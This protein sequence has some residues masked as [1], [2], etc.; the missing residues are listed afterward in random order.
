MQNHIKKSFF[1]ICLFFNNI[2]FSQTDKFTGIS[3]RLDSLLKTNTIRPF[4][5]EIIITEKGKKI[6]S[7]SLGYADFEKKIPLKLKNQFVI[8]SISKQITAVLILREFDKKHLNLNDPISKYLKELK[9]S[10]ADS[11]SIHQ[12]LNHTSGIV[13][14]NQPLAFKPGTK[15]SYSGDGY[16]LLGEIVERTSGNTFAVLLKKLFNKCKMTGSTDPGSNNKKNL[17]TGYSRQSDQTVKVEKETFTNN[18]VAAGLMISTVEDLIL[19]N[20]NLH[21][22]K[23]LSKESYKKMTTASSIRN[24]PIYGE[25]GYGY[26]IQ[27]NE[28]NGIL[29]LGHV[30]YVP[31]FVSINF[32][33]PKDNIGLI[34]LE[35]IDWK[36]D[37]FK[38]T[39][40]FEED[41]RRMVREASLKK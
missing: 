2:S 41:V 34:M 1:L 9:Q 40:C 24:H 28:K 12:L 22:G 26:G 15:F 33:Y 31:G 3:Q 36:D 18:I 7:Q 10:W 29:E 25:V 17:V 5:G 35:N 4:N 13:D 37:N 19:W 39:F 20:D 6:Y 27:I 38:E 32:Y 23:L 21:H 16:K 8:G 14:L 11:V 30:G